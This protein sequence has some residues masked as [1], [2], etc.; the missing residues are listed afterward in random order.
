MMA[1]SF[2]WAVEFSQLYHAPWIEA[3]RATFP[4]RLVLGATFKWPDLVAYLIGI[5]LGA[6]VEHLFRVPRSTVEK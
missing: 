3:V 6:V 1:L 2:A 4:G 5:A